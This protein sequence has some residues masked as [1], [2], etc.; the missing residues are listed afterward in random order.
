MDLIP[1]EVLNKGA[2]ILFSSGIMREFPL[3]FP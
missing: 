3:R 2:R 1:N